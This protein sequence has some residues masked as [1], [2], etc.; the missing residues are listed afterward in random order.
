MFAYALT[1]LKFRSKTVLYFIVMGCYMLLPGAVTYI[2]SYITLAK[3]GLL[4]SHMGLV[5]SNAA[6]VFR[7]VLST[8]CL[9]GTSL[10]ERL[11]AEELVSGAGAGSGSAWW[12]IIFCRN[13]DG[14]GMVLPH[15]HLIAGT[16]CVC[17]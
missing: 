2:P 10:M 17:C 12:K 7:C 14:H 9:S 13:A 8:W 6:S 5:A 15:R 3:L 16:S 1:Q 4:D 11:E